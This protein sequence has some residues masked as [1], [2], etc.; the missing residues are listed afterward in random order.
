MLRSRRFAGDSEEQASARSKNQRLRPP[1]DLQG[2]RRQSQVRVPM[3][4]ADANVQPQARLVDAGASPATAKS[5]PA[6]KTEA[7]GTALHRVCDGARRQNKM[8]MPMLLTKTT[9]PS[10]GAAGLTCSC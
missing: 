10:T 8:R 2:A 3:L 6:Q 7:T 4:R 1:Q 5:K 9:P